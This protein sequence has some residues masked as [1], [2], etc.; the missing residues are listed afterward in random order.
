MIKNAFI[1]G[2][3]G[4]L[5]ACI[6]F[7][8]NEWMKAGFKTT[9]LINIVGSLLI[10]L[11]IGVAQ[12]NAYFEQ[13]WRLFLATGLCGGFTT[14]SAFSLENV[15][16]LQQGK[17]STA[18]TYIIVSIVAGITAAWIGLKIAS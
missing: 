6:R 1:V 11:I 14:F 17:L 2:M 10:G 18:F 13:H 4:A 8:M 9:L 3:G 5:G 16:L 12:K 15:L 7:A